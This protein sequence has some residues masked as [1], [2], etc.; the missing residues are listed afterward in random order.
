MLGLYSS[1]YD[2]D[3]EN[4]VYTSPAANEHLAS[5]PPASRR[6]LYDDMRD[7]IER[8]SGHSIC[9]RVNEDG[10]KLVASVISCEKGK[11]VIGIS[12]L[13]EFPVPSEALL[14]DVFGLSLAEAR[15][16]QQIARGDSLEEIAKCASIKISTARSQLASVF[17]KTGTQRQAKL[18]ALLCRLAHLAK[19]PANSI[20]AA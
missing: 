4:Q 12:S 10:E 18:V 19:S 14:A 5:K 11:S 20:L 15:L 3:G 6:K 9:I 16:A 8:Q 17:A 7:R 13:F 2:Y 1:S